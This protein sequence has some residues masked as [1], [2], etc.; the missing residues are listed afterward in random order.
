MAFRSA[1]G[2][3]RRR[4]RYR[5]W[6]GRSGPTPEAVTR[7]MTQEPPPCSCRLG[8]AAAPRALLQVN[9]FEASHYCSAMWRLEVC[10]NRKHRPRAQRPGAM[11]PINCGRAFQSSPRSWIK[12]K[13]M[14]SP[15]WLSPKPIGRNC[16][17]PSARTPEQGGQTARRRRR[18]LSQRG[19]HHAPGRSHPAR[20]K[21][22]MAIAASLYDSGDYDH[23]GR[24]THHRPNHHRRLIT[25]R[26]D[27]PQI[28]TTLTHV[29]QPLARPLPCL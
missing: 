27:R 28:H 15:S 21:R 25:R 14:S 23:I 5:P 22:R 12:P 6:Y 2:F 9:G 20:A 18:H 11:S 24:R 16:I 1:A 8:L 4:Q 29:I 19:L 3:L 13:P 26:G 7:R 10:R 17:Q